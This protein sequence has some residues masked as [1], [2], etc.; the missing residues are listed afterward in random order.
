MC[1]IR[2]YLCITLLLSF[3]RLN[4]QIVWTSKPNDLQLFARSTTTNRATVTLSGRVSTSG[5]SALSVSVTQNGKLFNSQS[6]FLNYTSGSAGFKIDVIVISGRYNYDFNVYL[7][8]SGTKRLIYRAQRIACGDAYLITGQ[9]NSVAN[10]YVGF[11]NPTYKDSFIR[12]YGSSSASIPGVSDSNWYVA[13]GDALYNKG[14][15]GQWGLVLGKMILDSTGIPTC[16]INAGVGG[17]PITFHQKNYS[18]PTDISTNYGRLL[19]RASRAGFADKIRSIYWFQGESDGS[20]ATLHD[21]L[22]RKMHKDWLI[23]YKSVEKVYPV[24]IRSGCGSPSLLLR[25]KQRL[26]KT[27]PKCFVVTANGLNAHDGCHYGFLNGYESLGIQLFNV[28]K[29]DLYKFRRNENHYPLEP[30]SVYYCNSDQTLICME[31]SNPGA[32]LVVDT[33]FHQLIKLEGGT[34]SITNGWLYKNKIYLKLNKADCQLKGISYDGLP[35]NKPWVKTIKGVAM[36]SFLNFPVTKSPPQPSITVCK[37]QQV[38]LGT[39]SIP[40]MKYSWI[41]ARTGLK[42]NLANPVFKPT[43]TEKFMRIVTFTNSGCNMDT[44][45][46]SIVVDTIAPLDLPAKIQFCRNDSVKLGQT[47]VDWVNSYWFRSGSFVGSGFSYHAKQKGLYEQVV[48]AANGCKA[49]D[50]V[51]VEEWPVRSKDI[52]P[53]TISI[54]NGDSATLQSSIAGKNYFWNGSDLE[55]LSSIMVSSNAGINTLKMTDSNGCIWTDTCA[56]ATLYAKTIDMDSVYSVCKNDSLIVAL[57]NTHTAY[58]FNKKPIGRFLI[59]KNPQQQ[60][61]TA[62][63]EQGCRTSKTITTK[64]LPSPVVQIPDTGFCV[65]HYI[66]LSVPGVF[67]KY[68]WSSGSIASTS[69]FT[70][71]GMYQLSVTDS[72]GCVGIDSFRLKTANKPEPIISSDTFKCV[73]DTLLLRPFYENVNWSWQGLDYSGKTINIVNPGRYTFTSFYEKFCS[74]STSLRVRDV[75]CYNDIE[76]LDNSGDIR[77]WLHS[78]KIKIQSDKIMMTKALI[79]DIS[80]KRIKE[81]VINGKWYEEDFSDVPGNLWFIRIEGSN[82]TGHPQYYTT[83]ISMVY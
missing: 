60:I 43:L 21:S 57:P 51:L 44:A 17:T 2:L 30:G 3:E 50:S 6:S 58:T 42:F 80:G 15:I 40:G 81:M 79:Y 7:D 4:A 45:L 78:H 35:G 14:A 82:N 34:A 18:N 20:S 53:E 61:L 69:T 59:I 29:T 48:Y 36:Y 41:G 38:K 1:K 49:S 64:I 12:S 32:T 56:V 9:S 10:A 71:A 39:D 72:A 28:V 23:D 46:Q 25:D 47:H 63:D 5:Y 11:A 70:E 68:L 55:G 13:D 76:Y 8:S 37:G 62:S 16:F 22:Y 83:K 31:M 33:L 65:D 77:V 24:Q 54:C 73:G 52:L 19:L 74:T 67:L 66:K 75:T 27:L 26:L